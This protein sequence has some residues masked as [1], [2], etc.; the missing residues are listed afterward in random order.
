MEMFAQRIHAKIGPQ[1]LGQLDPQ[2]REILEGYA[3][4]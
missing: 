1:L 4:A 3:T 2:D